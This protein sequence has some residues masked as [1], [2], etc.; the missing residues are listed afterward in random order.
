M[1]LILGLVSLAAIVSMLVP[2][3]VL[4]QSDFNVFVTGGNLMHRLD[5]KATEAANGQV[6]PV[7]GFS[8]KPESVVQV[9]QNEVLQVFTSTNEPQRIEKIKLADAAGVMTDLV[10]NSLQGLLL[11]FIRWM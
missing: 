2:S 5:L 6:I 3:S 9:K 1:K 4:A 8:I 10:G 7:S 11:V